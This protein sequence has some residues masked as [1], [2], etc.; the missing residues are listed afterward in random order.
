MNLSDLLIA[1]LCIENDL[2]LGLS[3]AFFTILD[4]KHFPE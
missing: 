4:L 3:E 1:L 2:E